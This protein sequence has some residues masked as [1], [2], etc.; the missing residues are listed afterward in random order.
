[1]PNRCSP[2]MPSIARIRCATSNV[3]LEPRSFRLLT[4]RLQHV[5]GG[6]RD[7]DAE[8][9]VQEPSVLEAPQRNEADD[10]LGAFED[11]S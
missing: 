10:H 2:A 1:M 9:P 8:E 5:E 6:L 3:N 11:T 7:V 4:R